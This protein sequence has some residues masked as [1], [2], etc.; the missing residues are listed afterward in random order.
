MLLKSN[1]N[2]WMQMAKI[3]NRNAITKFTYARNEGI[4]TRT[5][6]TNITAGVFEKFL[7]LT[8]DEVCL[9]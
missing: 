5:G 6:H 8:L 7:F 4:V 1:N 2:I 9:K 3:L